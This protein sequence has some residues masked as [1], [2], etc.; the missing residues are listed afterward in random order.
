M[1]LC[2]VRVCVSVRVIPS[3]S[4]DLGEISG[5]VGLGGGLLGKVHRAWSDGEVG[6]RGW[7]LKDTRLKLNPRT[8]TVVTLQQ[9]FLEG[10]C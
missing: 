6:P 7:V 8:G 2:Q 10:E 1:G 5:G 9:L 3:A 4:E